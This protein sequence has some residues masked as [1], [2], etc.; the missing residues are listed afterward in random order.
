MGRHLRA[1]Q[2]RLYLPR[3]QMPL[4]SPALTEALELDAAEAH[5]QHGAG[6]AA[7][8][9]VIL[10]ERRR[11]AAAADVGE[12]TA[13]LARNEPAE[14]DHVLYWPRHDGG[15]TFQPARAWRAELAAHRKSLEQ[16]EWRLA[17]AQRR[18][19]EALAPFARPRGEQLEAAA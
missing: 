7:I 14:P 15:Q 12:L 19:R 17:E 8:H 5:P 11:D 6:W 1:L 9:D 18:A 3:D 4:S 10:A 16:L 2:D 13:F